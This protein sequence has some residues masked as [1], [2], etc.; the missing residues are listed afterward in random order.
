MGT[1]ANVKVEPMTVTFGTD[2]AQVVTIGYRADSAGDL[3][4]DYFFV[5]NAAGTKFHVWHNI[6]S[7]GS[8][9]APAG[10]TAI[11]VAGATG[12]T[13]AAL[14][15]AAATAIGAATGLDATASEGVVTVTCTG[16]GYASGPHEGVGTGF[17]FAVTTQ[18]VASADVGFTDGEIE[19]SMSEELVDVTAHQEGADVLSQIR[20]GISEVTVSLTLKETT[21]AQVKKML[22]MAGGSFT[23]VGSAATEVMGWG[24]NKRFTQTLAQAS[25]LV[26]HPVALPSSNRSRDIKF[27][28]AYPMLESLNFSGEDVFSIPV[29]FRCY[30]S[31]SLNDT[32][33]YFSLGDHTQTLT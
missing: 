11:E 29:T 33:E 26:L 17:T 1:V 3:N 24:R 32:V 14:A 10:S 7:A 31:T 4:N 18:G 15:T 22:A 23:P 5:Y 25:A 27:H 28:L 13:A 21:V 12:A 8:N 30:P 19:V 20:T 2:T 6:N 16:T 9:P